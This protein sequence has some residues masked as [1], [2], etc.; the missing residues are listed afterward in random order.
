MHRLTVALLFSFVF[1]AASQEPGELT[2]R[3]KQ[4][5]EDY[6]SLSVRHHKLPKDPGY[7]KGAMSVKGRPN[8]SRSYSHASDH[9]NR[10]YNYGAYH[11]RRSVRRYR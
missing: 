4:I 8:P 5:M 11:G 7:S 3:G 10:H 9:Y 1:S 6:G 2:E